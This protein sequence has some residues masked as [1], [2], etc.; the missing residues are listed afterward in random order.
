MKYFVLILTILVLSTSSVK[1]DLIKLICE[2]A[3]TPKPGDYTEAVPREFIIDSSAATYIEITPRRDNMREYGKVVISKDRFQLIGPHEEMF[4]NA[5]NKLGHVYNGAM[6]IDRLTGNLMWK[7]HDAEPIAIL[8][9]RK[10]KA[11]KPKF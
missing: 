8:T 10:L 2:R 1:A 4:Q 6:F 7:N 3:N 5:W 11:P 9:C